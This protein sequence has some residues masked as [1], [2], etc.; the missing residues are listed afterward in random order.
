MSNTNNFLKAIDDMVEILTGKKPKRALKKEERMMKRAR[1]KMGKYL[2][3]DPTT[4]DVN[5]AWI[6]PFPT[7]KPSIQWT[8]K[9]LIDYCNEFGVLH[10]EDDTK[11]QLLNKMNKVYPNGV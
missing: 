5:E 4:L 11:L 9:Q 2:G 7:P 3:D 10:S 8:R 6:S 1:D